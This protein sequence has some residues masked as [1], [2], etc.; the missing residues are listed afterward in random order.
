MDFQT[1][2]YHATHAQEQAYTTYIE[3]IDDRTLERRFEGVQIFY[4]PRSA[5]STLTK[6][7]YIIAFIKSAE[8][9]KEGIFH[10]HDAPGLAEV[11]EKRGKK[12]FLLTV[13]L[14]LSLEFLSVLLDHV[15][16]DD[17]PMERKKYAMIPK[18][19]HRMSM[20]KLLNNQALMCAPVLDTCTFDQVLPYLS[21][22]PLEVVD[23]VRE[24]DVY[25]VAL[26]KEH[27]IYEK[28]KEKPL[29]AWRMQDFGS[30]ETADAAKSRFQW[31]FTCEGRWYFFREM[32]NHDVDDDDEDCREG[33][34]SATHEVIDVPDVKNLPAYIFRWQ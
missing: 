20:L 13:K 21:C 7:Q 33:G 14:G 16:D 5:L 32:P 30:E 24:P 3:A 10:V 23:A 17:L 19:P 34:E 9:P 1:L 15:G 2:P 8:Y 12:L 31:G 29:K 26:H 6:R 25:N 22:F 11:I 28:E 27:L 4:L 18:G